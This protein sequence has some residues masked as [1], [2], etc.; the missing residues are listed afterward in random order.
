MRAAM[1]LEAPA[2][3]GARV[4]YAAGEIAGRGAVNRQMDRIGSQNALKAAI[5]Q[6]AGI[7][8]HGGDEERTVHRRFYLTCGMTVLQAMALSRAEMDDLRVTVEGWYSA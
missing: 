1:T 6:W 4:A 7:R 5:E 2:D 8:L 3:V